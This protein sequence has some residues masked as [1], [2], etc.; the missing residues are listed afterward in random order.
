MPDNIKNKIKD[1]DLQTKISNTKNKSI[2]FYQSDT[3]DNLK[4]G[5][6]SILYMIFIAY[7]LFR[8]KNK[9]LKKHTYEGTLDSLKGVKEKE[10]DQKLEEYIANQKSR[11]AYNSIVPILLGLGLF[12]SYASFT[13]DSISP[14]IMVGLL[15]VMFTIAFLQNILANTGRRDIDLII[16][17]YVT[18]KLSIYQLKTIIAQYYAMLENLQ[19]TYLSSKTN[20]TSV[21]YDIPLTKDNNLGL[22]LS[23]TVDSAKNMQVNDLISLDYL[24]PK[25]LGNDFYTISDNCMAVM[26]DIYIYQNALG[27]SFDFVDYFKD[28][29]EYVEHFRDFDY[30]KEEKELEELYNILEEANVAVNPTVIK[31]IVSRINTFDENNQPILGFKFKIA[32]NKISG[33]KYKLTLL[34]DLSKDKLYK[35]IYSNLDLIE[36][37]I[38]FDINIRPNP[39]SKSSFY[40]DITLEERIRNLKEIE[41]G[42]TEASIDPNKVKDIIDL[43]D[44]KQKE[45]GFSI[46]YD[47]LKIEG[48]D[49]FIE[50]V[51]DLNEGQTYNKIK[52][53]KNKDS[54]EAL[55]DYTIA[56]RKTESK[57]QAILVVYLN[58]S[59]DM[60]AISQ[61]DLQT[62]N[63]NNIIALGNGIKG[64]V[65]AKWKH[66]EANHMFINGGTNSGKTVTMRAFISQL[67]HLGED[68]ISKVVVTSGLKVNDY[69]QLANKGAMVVAGPELMYKTLV[70]INAYVRYC[71]QKLGRYTLKDGNV[72]EFNKVAKEEEKIKPLLFIADEFGSALRNKEYGKLIDT[73]MATLVA[74]ARA[75]N[76]YVF[77]LDQVPLIE[78]IGS[79]DRLIGGRFNGYNSEKLYQS[80]SPEIGAKYAK[81]ASSQTEII[82][83]LYFYSHPFLK[84]TNAETFGD[85]SFIEVRTPYITDFNDL[86]PE[87]TGKEFEKYLDVIDSDLS[88]KDVEG[89]ISVIEQDLAD[90]KEDTNTI[91]DPDYIEEVAEVLEFQGENEIEIPEA[92]EEKEEKEFDFSLIDL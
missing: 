69:K 32:N 42:I 52:E 26:L 36:K 58:E 91:K 68:P 43:L 4:T 85:T 50:V 40:L 66:G 35:N 77:L 86:I 83:G 21:D 27:E 75:F 47:N 84:A 15:L 67:T 33:D 34:C 54:I 9:L 46:P 57:N 62:Y 59:I 16:K 14:V 8:L 10:K 30:I 18:Q 20:I 72:K 82:N 74:N 55:I 5:F 78:S 90:K 6:F 80:I 38:G 17:Y 63:D 60:L 88:P 11:L 31:R 22:I 79:S 44:K 65:T 51:I 12:L 61:K 87:L 28:M 73:E 19:N 13:G 81:V 49:R 2:D 23:I 7:P 89:Y 56:I 39:R 1:L 92:V 71:E 53:R 45:F 24:F 48:N 25:A 29:P 64:L 70:L 41:K 37:T 3:F 76:V